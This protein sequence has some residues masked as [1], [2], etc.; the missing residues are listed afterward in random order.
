MGSVIVIYCENM[1]ARR[2]AIKNNK[3]QLTSIQLSTDTRDA[4]KK[5]GRMDEDWE[6]LLKRLSKQY[7]PITDKM[8]ERLNSISKEYN[9]DRDFL[10]LIGLNIIIFLADSGILKQLQGLATSKNKNMIE[11][12][13]EFIRF[14]LK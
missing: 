3:I 8:D 9:M 7:I 5:F 4:L 2:L 6:K 11:L 13:A 1:T 14:K 12:I 10:G